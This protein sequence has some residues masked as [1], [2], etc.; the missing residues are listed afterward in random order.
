MATTL[1]PIHFKF[2]LLSIKRS[3][4]TAKPCYTGNTASNEYN[5]RRMVF[6]RDYI[7]LFADRLPIQGAHHG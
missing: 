2:V 5:A 3:E 7:M 4:T 1:A 6:V